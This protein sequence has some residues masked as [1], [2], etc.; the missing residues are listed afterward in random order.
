M[1]APAEPDG[2]QEE[3]FELGAELGPDAPLL[4]MAM[5]LS[6]LTNKKDRERVDLL[7]HTV[8]R[9][10]AEQT[11]RPPEP[12]PVRIHSPIK[13]S[14]PW[15]EDDWTPVD[16]Y[17]LNTGKIWLETDAL[18][19]IADAGGS[20]GMGQEL[21]WG[22]DLQL[23]SLYL[24][25]DGDPVSRQING[26]NSEYDLSVEAYRDSD[27]LHDRVG[28]WL[29]SRKAA[30]LDGPRRRRSREL[31]FG[32]A[33]DS[34][35]A[36]WALI[37]S[38]EQEHVVA[39]T[40]IARGRIKRMLSHPLALAAASFQ[41]VEILRGA[42][43]IARHGDPQKELPELRPAQRAAL[44]NAAEELEWDHETVL[45]LQRRA[46][47]ELGAGGVRRLTLG[48]IQDWATFYKLRYEH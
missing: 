22:F 5:P 13:L 25:P 36:A 10:I 31:I 16:V 20:M 47:V 9:A 3:L 6:H 46:Q 19:M 14:A 39:T 21:E 7:A 45:D 2:Q 48:S 42:L 23:P 32:Q 30:I 43:G 40:R 34:L 12:W 1:T 8:G 37:S 28:R 41:E 26:A 24:Y 38:A 33:G 4:Y 27:D 18:I 11:R 29:A 15:R 35:A 17:E 44:C